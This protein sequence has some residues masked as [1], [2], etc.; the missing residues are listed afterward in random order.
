MNLYAK[1][2]SQLMIIEKQTQKNKN[3][4]KQEKL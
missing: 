3:R 4:P 2:R 1:Y